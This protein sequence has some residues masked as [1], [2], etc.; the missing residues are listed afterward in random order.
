MWALILNTDIEESKSYAVSLDRTNPTMKLFKQ[1]GWDTEYVAT[2]NPR[3]AFRYHGGTVF[4]KNRKSI[5][6]N[7]HDYLA[8]LV[9]NSTK[10]VIRAN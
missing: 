6:F 3:S 7:V 4:V 2:K 10:Y 1:T 9:M 5:G 8:Q